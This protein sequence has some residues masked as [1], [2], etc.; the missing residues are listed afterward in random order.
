MSQG[1]LPLLQNHYQNR[2]I[3]KIPPHKL[4]FSINF[5]IF[6]SKGYKNIPPDN[7]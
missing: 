1:P 2:L 5:L 7:E 4:E 3:L 6:A